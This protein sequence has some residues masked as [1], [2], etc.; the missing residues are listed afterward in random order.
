MANLVTTTVNG[1]VSATTIL[2]TQSDTSE[3]YKLGHCV[4]DGS[5]YS[6]CLGTGY[7]YLHVRTP[8]PI[9]SSAGMGWNPY[10]LEV[11]GYHTYSG[12]RFHDWVAVVNTNGYT[13][14]GFYGSYV[15][16]NRSLTTS[17]PYVYASSNNYGGYQRMCF[18]MLKVS[19]CCTGFFWVRVRQNG[20]GGY[21]TQYPWATFHNNSQTAQVF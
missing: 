7:N 8:W 13:E 18:S 1:N 19:C 20:A 17:D 6:D 21:R 12:E 2:D 11:V 3:W 9:N 15:R 4:C 16:I 14:T 5:A 10:I